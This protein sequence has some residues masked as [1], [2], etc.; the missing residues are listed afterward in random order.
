MN[1][2]LC[3]A[4]PGH[5]F[6]PA[7]RPCCVR[8]GRVTLTY[9]VQLRHIDP[10]DNAKISATVPSLSAASPIEPTDKDESL[11]VIYHRACIEPFY[12]AAVRVRLT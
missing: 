10:I 5:A 8:G 11:F 6:I 7:L 4:S 12:D 2:N 1:Y 9:C 3:Q